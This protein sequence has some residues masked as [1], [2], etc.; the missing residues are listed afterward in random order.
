MEVILFLKKIW[1]Y[2]KVNYIM[3][4]TFKKAKYKVENLHASCQGPSNSGQELLQKHDT[5][6]LS[7]LPSF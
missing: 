1:V 7:V 4:N 2:F 3:Y 6:F 5:Q